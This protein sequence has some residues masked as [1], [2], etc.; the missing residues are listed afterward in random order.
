MVLLQSIGKGRIE[1]ARHLSLNLLLTYVRNRPFARHHDSPD[2]WNLPTDL[3]GYGILFLFLLS[4]SGG[5]RMSPCVVCTRASIPLEREPSHWCSSVCSPSYSLVAGPLGTRHGSYR[6]HRTQS[7]VRC[8]GAGTF[9]PPSGRASNKALWNWLGLATR[10]LFALLPRGIEKHGEEP[11]RH[12]TNREGPHGSLQKMTD[13]RPNEAFISASTVGRIRANNGRASVCLLP[14]P[15][16]GLS[17]GRRDERPA[18]HDSSRKQLR[19]KMK[20]CKRP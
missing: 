19:K 1:P 17:I 12:R 4:D 10:S 15:G 8:S 7:Y 5:R 16:G 2:I 9:R 14:P 11:D 3:P 6:R 18:V 13:H 20:R